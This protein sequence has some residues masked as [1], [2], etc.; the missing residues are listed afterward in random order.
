ML[1][2][3]PVGVYGVPEVI[4]EYDE[5]VGQVGRLLREGASHEGLADYF[6]K[7]DFGPPEPGP[8]HACCQADIGVVQSFDGE[9]GR[10]RRLEG[11]NGPAVVPLH[12]EVL[13]RAAP[14]GRL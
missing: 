7:H 13:R 14:V 11:R 2:W 8:R 9:A 4:D 12:R 10:T 5:Y 6:S 1:W 3:D